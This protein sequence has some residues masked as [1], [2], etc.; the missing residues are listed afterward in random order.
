MDKAIKDAISRLDKRFGETK[1]VRKMS[2][3]SVTAQTF[4]SGRPPLDSRLGGGYGVGKIIEVYGESAT[5]KS[6][7][8]LEA[9]VQAQKIKGAREVAYIDTE[10]ALNLNYA[11]EIGVNVDNMLLS[12]PDSLE[13]SIE[14][15]KALTNTGKFSLIVVDSVDAMVP[16]A[17]LDGESGESKMGLKPRLMN[18]GLRMIKGILAKNDTTV[19]FINQ[20]RDTMAMYGPSQTTTGGKGLKFYASQRL[21]IKNR[22]RIKEGDEV[23][24]F[25]QQVQVTKNKIGTPYG[26]ATF[27]IVYGVGVDKLTG[28]IDT[29]VF[30]E[31][32]EK[33]SGGVYYFKDTK[34]CRGAANLRSIIGENEEMLEEMNVLLKNKL[35]GKGE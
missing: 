34:I 8:A 5:G 25:K 11:K 28:L 20:L 26:I 19:I 13:Q 2:D 7:L 3:S 32:I 31:V 9:I 6:G 24:G 14:I 29:L 30:E 18:Q 17:E 16:Q 23:V 35:S 15:I 22:G 33:R 27:D 12:Q 4:S 1:I 10:Q 21:E